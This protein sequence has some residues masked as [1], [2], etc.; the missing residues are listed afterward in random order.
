M[1]PDRSI[2]LTSIALCCLAACKQKPAAKPASVAASHAISQP[3]TS[4]T[5][6]WTGLFEHD[7]EEK[8]FD[9]AT[10]DSVVSAD[11]KITLFI[12]QM[13]DG[14]I[15]GY[16]ICAGNDRAFTGSYEENDDK[17]TATLKEPG[18]HKNDG[19]FELVISKN[20]RTLTGTWKPY[21]PTTGGRHYNLVRKNFKYNAS[22]GEHPEASMR[23][24]TADDVNNLYKDELR[25]IRNEIYARHGYSFKLA[26]VRQMFEGFD[27]YMPIS[28]DVRKKL[29]AVEVKNEEMIKHYEKYAEEAYDDYGR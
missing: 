21:K 19:V 12:D 25:F 6:T 1:T 18:D 16:S 8:K 23:L 9:K 20:N 26:E 3:V 29:T 24:L 22:L 7:H 27:W 28:T 15:S 4:V 14:D 13:E 11:N 10:G 17:I 2:V 5:G